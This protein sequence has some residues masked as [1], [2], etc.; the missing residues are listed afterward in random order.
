MKII[1]SI[2][3]ISQQFDFFIFD[4][5]G[6][7]HDGSAAYPGAIEAIKFLRQ[8]NKKI[9]FLSN[10]PRRA[11]KVAATL[12]KFGVSEDLY[13]FV[14]SSGEATYLY[15]EQ[16]QRDNFRNFGKNYFYIGPQKDIDLLDGLNYQRVENASE[17][18]FAITT[19]FDHDNSVLDEKMPQI[20]AAKNHDLP[21]I[22]VNPDL[23]VV[24]QNG[25]EMICAGLIAAE[26][27]KI[28]GKVI[29]YGKPYQTVYETVCKKFSL[30]NSDDLNKI[31]AVGDGMETDILGAK[32]F[33]INSLLIT[34]GIL[35]N[36]L[37]IKFDQQ[38][39]IQDLEQVFSN[40]KISPQ[41]VI[42]N[43]KV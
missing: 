29:Y 41:F 13:D 35:S 37:K 39:N 12:H 42:S 3:E 21:M 38:A 8:E 20:I 40:Y 17:A 5:W 2:R 31:I 22:C 33:G 24:K 36:T 15:L 34:G 11:N 28:G 26:Y 43:L 32:N 19:G 1:H 14:M 30:N 25:Q 10:A 23:I 7:V 16:N 4:V 27:K 6:V 9:C 18:D